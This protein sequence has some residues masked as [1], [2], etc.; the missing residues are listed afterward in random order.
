LKSFSRI[1]ARYLV[2]LLVTNLHGAALASLVLKEA[3]ERCG[4]NGEHEDVA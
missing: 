2:Q 4:Q 1:N 3:E